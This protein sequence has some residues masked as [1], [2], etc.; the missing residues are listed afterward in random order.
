M[1]VHFMANRNVFGRLGYIVPIYNKMKY[2]KYNI[3]KMSFKI[4]NYLFKNN[5]VKLIN[6]YYNMSFKKGMLFI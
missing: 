4:I 5:Y 2:D 1:K 6:K 3:S